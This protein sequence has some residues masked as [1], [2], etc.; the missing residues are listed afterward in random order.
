MQKITKVVIPAAGFGTRFLPATKA[1]PKEMLPIVDKPVIQYAAE[2]AV[3]AGIKD[4][5]FIIGRNKQS[6]EDHFDKAY[7][8]EAELA[9]KQKTLLIDSVQAIV[10]SF[11]NCIFIRQP[12]ALGLGHAIHCARPVISNEPFAIILP[13]DL[14]DSDSCGCLSQMMDVYN[15]TGKSVLAVERVKGP[16]ISKYGVIEIEN[17]ED[18]L[19][20]IKTIVEKPPF[21]SAPSDLGVVGRYILSYKVMEIL[22]RLPPGSGGEIQLT[23]GIS[24]LLKLEDINAFEFYGTRFDCGSKLGFLK[25]NIALGTKSG[26]VGES[27]ISWIK[28]QKF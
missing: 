27:L 14:I 6:I 20:K 19:G 18:R 9:A 5:I 21:E 25:A 2:E 11:V 1:N 16:E 3:A 26:E 8:L 10:P 17:F 13:D 22:G 28:E 15:Q 12:T 4:I 23:D 24:E 7:E